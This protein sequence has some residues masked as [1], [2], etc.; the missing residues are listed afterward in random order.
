MIDDRIC[1]KPHIK[2]IQTKLSKSISVLSKA[3]HFLN[4][5]SLHI[6]Y[7]SNYYCHICITVQKSVETQPVKLITTVV[8][9]SKRAVR[10]IHNVTFHENTNQLF[11]QSNT[12]TFPD[13]VELKTAQTIF[14]ARNNMLPKNIQAM[15]SEREGGY[16]I[17][18]Q[19]NFKVRHT[20]TTKKVVRNMF[21]Y[22]IYIEVNLSH[23]IF[24]IKSH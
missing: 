8:H 15:F 6:L 20:C 18:G 1:W 10:L 16:T 13:L 14:K 11:I 21:I 22:N 4:N 5:E 7:N 24:K 17:M 2:Y 3:K 12:I 19:L 9:S 23:Q